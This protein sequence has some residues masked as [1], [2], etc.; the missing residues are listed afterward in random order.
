MIVTDVV[1][2][3]AGIAGLSAAHALVELGLGVVVVEATPGFRDRIRGE[4]L[5][6]WGAAEAAKLG[7]IET[8]RLADGQELPIWQRYEDRQP[9][10]PYAWAEDVPD[11]HVEWAVSHPALQERLLEALLG[12]VQQVIRP[13]RFRELRMS[14]DVNEVDVV[15]GNDLL[16]IAPR[17]VIGAD[18]QR[19]SVRKAIGGAG[20][21]DPVHHQLGGLL[22]D[23]VALAADRTH[24]AFFPGGMTVLFPRGE[25]RARAYLACSPAEAARLRGPAAIDGFIAA[26]AAPFPAGALANSRPA[27]AGGFFPGADVVADRLTAPGV[28][29]IGD[30]A[31]ANDPSQG[32]GLSLAFRDARELR[33]LLA[34]ERDWQAAIE[35]FGRR[36]QRYFAPLRAHA[37]WAGKLTTET[38]PGADRVRVRAAR[39]RDA[40][41]TLGGYAGIHAFGP[42]GLDTSETARRHFFGED[43]ER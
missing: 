43:L 19:S 1:I 39:A 26:C 37:I 31:G 34:D 20:R 25:G 12:R 13:G 29:L 11:G 2:I 3:G 30:A 32:H 14:G 7:L 41:P 17:L 35:E 15:V 23:G 33:D 28:V 18:G 27:G 40:D 42:D 8:L 16:T 5:H 6:P 36:R 10:A 22:L 4:A 38:G 9:I 21:R 24:Q